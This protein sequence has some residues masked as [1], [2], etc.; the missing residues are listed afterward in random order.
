ML[1]YSQATANASPSLSTVSSIHSHNTRLNN[2]FNYYIPSINTNLGKTSLTYC[3]PKIWNSIPL[4]IRSLP[5]HQFKI[6]Y[7]N[8]LIQTYLP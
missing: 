8:H 4:D 5:P 1:K 2:P 7:K 6:L 3:G